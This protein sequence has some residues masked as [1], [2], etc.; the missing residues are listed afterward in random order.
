M[1]RQGLAY[2]DARMQWWCTKCQTV[3]ANEQ[4]IDG[5]CWRHDAADDPMVEKEVKQWFSNYR[6]R[7]R[8]ASRLRMTWTGQ[9]SSKPPRLNWIGK[10]DGV[11]YKN[12]VR[13]TNWRSSHFRH[14]LKLLLR[15]RLLRLPRITHLLPTLV[16]GLPNKEDIPLTGAGDDP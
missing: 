11:V 16:D 1:Y 13:D 10:S 2:Q 3:L 15:I 5:K 12:K 4:V 14:T 8:T 6:L 9:M 7:R